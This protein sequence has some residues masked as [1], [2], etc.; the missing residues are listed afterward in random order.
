MESSGLLDHLLVD[1]LDVLSDAVAVAA[2]GILRHAGLVLAGELIADLGLHLGECGLVGRRLLHRVDEIDEVP[3][4]KGEVALRPHVAVPGDDRGE[5]ELL[6]RGQR[7]DP[8]LRVAVV[9]ERHQV[10]KRAP[11]REDLLLRQEGKESAL[12][13][14]RPN[15]CSWISRPPS[16]R[17]KVVATVRVGRA[18]F[19]DFSS[20]R[21]DSAWCRLDSR[22]FFF[23]GSVSFW[24]SAF[25]LSISPGNA[26]ICFSMYGTPPTPA[27]GLLRFSLVLS[28][29][30][31][32]TFEFAAA[33]DSLP[34]Q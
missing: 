19:I 13:W 11:V 34:C 3:A 1:H 6:Q 30:M 32:S 22:F 28:L 29:A 4:E 8:L 12:V 25:S 24:M 33:Y 27:S 7:C 23:W 2:E 15:T 18:G 26:A 10:D 31:I 20:C 5:I 14:A 9:H 16:F 21:N 17:V